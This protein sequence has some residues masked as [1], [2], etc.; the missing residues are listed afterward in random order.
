MKL[1]DHGFNYFR[2][3]MPATLCGILAA[4]SS[5][6]A[7]LPPQS[8]SSSSISRDAVKYSFTTVDDSHDLTF[9]RILG[10]NNEGR[11]AGYYGSG[12][13]SHP[14]RG[15][16][17]RPPYQQNN[18]KDQNFPQAVDTQ[19]TS[20]NNKRTI[21]GFFV[22][23]KGGIYGA[24]QS[25]GI[26]TK[27]GVPH[28]RDPDP[29]TE[30][31]GL[32]DSGIGVGYYLTQSSEEVPVQVSQARGTFKTIKV[33][34]AVNA[35]ATGITGRGHVVGYMQTTSGS[36]VGFFLVSGVLS[37][38]AYPGATQT[39]ALCISTYDRVVGSYVDTYG[40]THGF[41]V[42]G[43]AHQYPVWQ[44]IDEPNAAGTTVVTGINIHEDI[45]GYYVDASGN[46]H[47]FVAKASTARIRRP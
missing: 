19:I 44:S 42:L 38:L 16:V 11:L 25:G 2:A 30:I 29:V 35:V 15:Y 4:C 31:L 28:G 36:V 9:N 7:Q 8:S 45:V 34:G 24:M 5:S 40:N 23:S 47:G 13:P 41:L 27:Y 21:A 20:V 18:F 46:T 10:L 3:A 22:D 17:V 1:F 32:N 6:N 14:N 43:P 39:E 33:P 26:W 37:P 12:S